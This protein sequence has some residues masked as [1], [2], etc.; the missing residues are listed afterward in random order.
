M[1]D[2]TPE[3]QPEDLGDFMKKFLGGDKEAE[4][5][6]AALEENPAQEAWVGFHELYVSLRSGGFN[7]HEATDIMAGYL[8]RLIAGGEAN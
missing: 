8:Y 7:L 5:F 6:F 4:Q 3:E 2:E 1:A